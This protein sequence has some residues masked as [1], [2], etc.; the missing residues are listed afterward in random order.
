MFHPNFHKKLEAYNISGTLS[1]L[2]MEQA[3]LQK[4]ALSSH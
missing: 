4:P 3:Q 2:P 1:P